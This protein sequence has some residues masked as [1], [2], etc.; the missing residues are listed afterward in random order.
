MQ[1]IKIHGLGASG[2]GVGKLDGLTVFV[3]G[4]LPGEEVLAEIETRKKNSSKSSKVLRSAWSR[5]ARCIKIAAAV[6]FNI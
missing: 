3:E 1:A 5:F 2:E 6:N 4:A